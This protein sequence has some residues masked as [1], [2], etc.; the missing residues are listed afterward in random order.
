MPPALDR[1]EPTRMR[2]FHARPDESRLLTM[3][4]TA[5]YFRL[6]LRRFGSTPH[7]RAALVA[8]T[9]AGDEP[10]HDGGGAEIA[11]RDQLRQLANVEPLVT[12]SWGLELG[13]TLD[14]ATHGPAGLVIVTAGSLDSALDGAVRY[15]TIRTPFVDL[16]ARREPGRYVLRVVEPCDLGPV[17]VPLLELVLLSL[18]NVIESALG[19][20]IRE[21]T[22]VMPA[23]R[24]AYWRRYDEFFHGP[25]S[26]AGN[27]AGLSL[28]AAWLSM[29]CPLADPLAHRS[30]RAR[31][32][33]MRQRLA[34]DFL[35]VQIER[36]LEQS[37]AAAPPLPDAAARLRVSPRTLVRRLGERG[38]S[39]RALVDVHRRRRAADLL[40][41][42]ALPV[43][44]V[45]D[46][47]GYDEP[48]N[49]GRACRRWFGMSPRAYRQR[50][51]P[52]AHDGGPALHDHERGRSAG[53]VRYGR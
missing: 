34:G 23:P 31:L 41:Q 38:T 10:A 11:V 26:F 4:M 39:Y 51:A 43:A 17:R 28:P 7:R 22:F 19:R 16:R 3:P 33:A 1:A 45:A 35:D 14:C 40:C 47:L 44:E 36:L 42:P 2:S 21:A 24:P 49:F 8:G 18:Q 48:T 13:A 32:E 46:R 12:A 27:E 6:I 25:V 53:A 5:A 37:D 30:A 29:P 20:R 52:A 9:D 50:A 15:M